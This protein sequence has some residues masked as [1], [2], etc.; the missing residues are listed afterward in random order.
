MSDEQRANVGAA[1]RRTPPGVPVAIDS[2]STDRYE[3][4]N[5]LRAMRHRRPTAARLDKL[6]VKHDELVKAVNAVAISHGELH[7][8]MS[9]LLEYGAAAAA[10]AD[11]RA[12]AEL[13]ATESSRKHTIALI[14][15][16][17]AAVAAIVTA[18][19]ALHGCS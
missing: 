6:E 17:A 2:D 13:K 1:H 5:E 15:A 18:A 11:R 8:K 7:G 9:T 10:E 4:P 19:A 3:D 16:L 12:A 14:G